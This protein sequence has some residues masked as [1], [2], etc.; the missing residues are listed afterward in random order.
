[1][2]PASQ[3]SLRAWSA[4]IG[5]PVPK[6][7]GVWLSPSGRLSRVMVTTTVASTPPASG[8]PVDG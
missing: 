8:E 6:R 4:V 5:S 3:T 1:M 2:I 7:A